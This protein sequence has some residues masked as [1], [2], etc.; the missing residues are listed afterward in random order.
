MNCLPEK[1]GRI[2]FYRSLLKDALFEFIRNSKK[3][4]DRDKLLNSQNPQPPKIKFSIVDKR[5][6]IYLSVEDNGRGVDDIHLSKLNELGF[7]EGGHGLHMFSYLWKAILGKQFLFE[8]VQYQYF[9]I[10]IPIIIGGES[11]G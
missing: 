8:S 6:G 1:F 3:H 11:E 4:V 5:S 7:S 9:R 10:M 2:N